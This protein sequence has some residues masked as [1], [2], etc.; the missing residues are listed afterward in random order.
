[1][2]QRGENEAKLRRSQGGDL[3]LEPSSPGRWYI[4]P[5]AEE[6]PSQRESL[7]PLPGTQ[8]PRPVPVF[9]LSAPGAVSQARH[10]AVP[11]VLPLRGTGGRL[12]C[13]AGPPLQLADLLVLRQCCGFME[14][15]GLS[16]DG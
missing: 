15:R 1:M 10:R 4:W 7:S 12:G 11:E 8:H 14:A 16:E 6:R 3:L 2:S 13:T 5:S 9:R